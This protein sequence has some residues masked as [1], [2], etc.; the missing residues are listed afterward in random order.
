MSA[1]PGLSEIYTIL[2]LYHEEKRLPH[3]DCNFHTGTVNF[4]ITQ[5]LIE[6]DLSSLK[7]RK[8]KYY[9]GDLNP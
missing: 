1:T 8:I 4:Y 7:C 9:S 2:I 3:R 6:M 5:G